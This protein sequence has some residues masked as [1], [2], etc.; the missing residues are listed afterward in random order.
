M[1]EDLR[2]YGNFGTPN[3]FFELFSTLNDKSEVN[4][5]KTDIEKLFYNQYHLVLS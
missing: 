5:S 1:L 3:Y 4:Y 2:K